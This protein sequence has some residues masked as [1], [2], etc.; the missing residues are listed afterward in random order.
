MEKDFG[1]AYSK[2]PHTGVKITASEFRGNMYI[3]IREYTLDGDTGKMYPTKSG[4]AMPGEHLDSVIYR[5][6]QVSNFL[7][8]YYR[9]DKNQLSFD[10]G[11]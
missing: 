7:G 6:E 1:I 2:R 10:F 4:Y 3:H 11:D 8:H 9:Q 5:L